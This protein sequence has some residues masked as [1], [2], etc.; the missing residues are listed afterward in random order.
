LTGVLEHV[1]GHY[2]GIVRAY[3]GIAASTIP[4]A[5]IPSEVYKGV[6]DAVILE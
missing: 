4:D 2:R 6:V 3:K 5:A 1:Q